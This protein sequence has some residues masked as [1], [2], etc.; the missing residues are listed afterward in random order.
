MQNMHMM[1]SYQLRITFHNK[2]GNHIVKYI[3]SMSNNTYQNINRS[4]I[5]LS[6]HTISTQYIMSYTL[7]YIRQPNGTTPLL[8]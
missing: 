4:Q 7:N 8:C 6:N 5:H 1:K 2:S 3:N